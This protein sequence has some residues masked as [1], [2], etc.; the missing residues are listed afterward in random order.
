MGDSELQQWEKMT[1]TSCAPG[2]EM[3][4]VISQGRG[5]G[6]WELSSSELLQWEEMTSTSCAPGVR[7][8]KGG[9]LDGSISIC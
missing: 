5:Q 9:S 7:W 4:Q 1:S 6:V 3:G 2:R 8:V